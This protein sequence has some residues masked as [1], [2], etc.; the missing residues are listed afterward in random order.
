MSIKYAK[1]PEFLKKFKAANREEINK[2]LDEDRA[3]FKA[4]GHN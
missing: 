3:L 2:M 4:T 1:D